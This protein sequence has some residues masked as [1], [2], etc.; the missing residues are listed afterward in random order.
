MSDYPP[1]PGAYEQPG[2]YPPP[3]PDPGGYE[4]HQPAPGGYRQQYY[5]PPP[6]GSGLQVTRSPPASSV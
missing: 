2:A 3:P 6:L 5:T 4:Q 1:R